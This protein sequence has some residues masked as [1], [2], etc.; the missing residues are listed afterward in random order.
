MLKFIWYA[1]D[2]TAFDGAGLELLL[3]IDFWGGDMSA[4]WWYQDH[5]WNA[6]IAT[7]ATRASRV[8]L[9]GDVPTLPI[10]ARPSNDLFKTTVYRQYQQLGSFDFLV[11]MAEAPAY[12]ARRRF[13]EA[14]MARAASAHANCAFV[15]VSPYFTHSKTGALHVSV[16][17]VLL[18]LPLR[19]S[20]DT[21]E[22]S[23]RR[24]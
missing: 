18:P 4:P 7:L 17:V 13:Q 20:Y 23:W 9:F 6:T 1:I 14:E 16:C 10:S 11:E 2:L 22:S 3:Y 12:S 8:K 5:D 15:P 21:D 19:P 24:W